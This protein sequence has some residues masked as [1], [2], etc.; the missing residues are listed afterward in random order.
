MRLIAAIVLIECIGLGLAWLGVWA[1]D[2]EA[3]QPIAEVSDREER[4]SLH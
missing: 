2:T 1:L 3:E 4:G